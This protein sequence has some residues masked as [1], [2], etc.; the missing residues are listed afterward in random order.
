ML[1]ILA[2]ALLPMRALVRALVLAV[3]RVYLPLAPVL[4]L[5]QLAQ[6]RPWAW[7]LVR[8][9]LQLPARGFVPGSARLQER[10]VVRALLPAQVQ[11]RVLR[12]GLVQV[13]AGA[14]QQVQQV[15]QLER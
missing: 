14:R 4:A 9:Q 12:Q 11:G 3:R 8:V 13:Q 1:L 2:Q 7:L 6:L 5:R 10:L 15:L